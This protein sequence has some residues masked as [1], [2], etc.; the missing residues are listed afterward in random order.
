MELTLDHA[1]AL[2][3]ADKADIAARW[4]QELPAPE[5]AG[6]P[7]VALT[8]AALELA[9]GHAFAGEDRLET[10][11]AAGSSAAARASGSMGSSIVARRLVRHATGDVRPPGPGRGG[12]AVRE[13]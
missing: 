12:S 13:A 5:L 2:H 4:L 9:A 8:L 11:L 7:D 1:P 10:L 3:V 6:R